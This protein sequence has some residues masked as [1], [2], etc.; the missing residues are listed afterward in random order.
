MTRSTVHTSDAPAAIGPYSQAI[1][2]G[3]FVFTSGQLAIDP[4]TGQL[5]TGDISVQTHQVFA[6][7]KA[8]LAAAGSSLDRVVKATCFLRDMNDFKAFNAVYGE[9]LGAGKPARSTVQVARLPLD[10]A[11]EIDL[12]ALCD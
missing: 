7:L 9:Y 6:N 5:L 1:K 11:V 3:G 12:V 2:A 8:V 4:K 10:G